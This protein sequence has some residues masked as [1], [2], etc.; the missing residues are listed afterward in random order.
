MGAAGS[1]L[2]VTVN[3]CFGIKQIEVI[4]SIALALINEFAGIPRQEYNRVLRLYVFRV[5]FFVEHLCQLA[6]FCVVLAKFGMV[7]VAVYFNQVEALLVRCPTDVRK[8]A[9]GRVACIQVNA[10]ARCGVVDTYLH[11]VAGHS[12]HWIA[13]IVHFAHTCGNVY[14]RVL[15]HHTFIH[16]VEGE[17]IT[18]RAP[19]C[20]FVDTE[21]IAVYGLA[22]DD[23]F[24]LVRHRLFV[25]V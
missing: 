17:Q 13:D 15:S 2:K 6:C 8:V 23:A 20:T 1:F 11:L 19:E 16:T 10:F 18:F 3:A 22:A 4:V 5:S 12:C 25:Y 21:L 24:G 9:V 14:K 7:L